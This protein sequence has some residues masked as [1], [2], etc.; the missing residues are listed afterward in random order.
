MIHPIAG[1]DPAAALVRLDDVT[2]RL[3]LE[4]MMVQTEKLLALGG[5]A[6]GAAHEIN[7]PLSGVLQNSQ[8]VLRRLAPDLETNREVAAAVGLDIGALQAYVE[9]RKIPQLLATV[10]DSAERASHIVTDMLAFSRRSTAGFE[11]VAVAEMLETAVRLVAGDYDMRK[12]YGFHNLELER[13]F[14]PQL[15]FVYCDRIRIEQVLINLLK[16]ATQ[17]MAL[18]G[19]PPPRRILIRTRRDEGQVCIEVQDNG[20]G[21]DPEVRSRIFEPFFTTKAP[22]VGNGLGL[23]VAHF[24]VSQQHGGRIDVN[25]T[26][27]KGSCFCLRL[28]LK[29]PQAAPSALAIG[30]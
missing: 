21:I 4:Q 14:D 13:Q 19:T 9:R 28:P 7:S 10:R 3:G 17:A 22:G 16:N 5:L 11:K 29:P 24:I 23:S 1:A 26:P 12:R 25:S 18:A 27:G 6:A 30:A 15:P 20:P 8:N 2:E